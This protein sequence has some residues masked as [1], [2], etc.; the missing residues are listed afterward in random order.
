L[1][2]ERRQTKRLNKRIEKPKE[3]SIDECFG[4]MGDLEFG[5]I[6]DG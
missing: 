3:G 5:L 2:E 4:L 1:I 6:E